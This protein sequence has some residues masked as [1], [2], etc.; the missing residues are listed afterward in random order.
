MG[1]YWSTPSQ[2]GTTVTLEPSVKKADTDAARASEPSKVESAAKVMETTSPITSDH[3]EVYVKGVESKK[4]TNKSLLQLEDKPKVEPVPKVEPSTELIKELTKE[5]KELITEL[6]KDEPKVQEPKVQ[7]PKVEES[8]LQ[9]NPE[10]E[11]VV[12]LTADELSDKILG[13]YED[14]KKQE[15]KVLHKKVCE[16]LLVNGKQKDAAKKVHDQLL[17]DVPRYETIKEEAIVQSDDEMPLSREQLKQHVLR[18]LDNNAKKVSVKMTE[19]TVF[20][21]LKETSNEKIKSPSLEP[22]K[23]ESLY[24]TTHPYLLEYGTAPIKTNTIVI[25]NRSYQ[26]LNTITPVVKL[27]EESAAATQ[28]EQAKPAKQNHKHHKKNNKHKKD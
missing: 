26:K 22:V 8:L 1:N 28:V 18:E 17:K 6:T 7:E 25:E 19:K 15:V 14:C 2:T 4:E 20:E 11:N 13:I 24:E 5:V 21:Y 9:I 3:L 16:E 12:I 10:D 27:I 23:E